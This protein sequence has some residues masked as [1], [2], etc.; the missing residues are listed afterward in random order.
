M[1]KAKEED[2][3]VVD[4]TTQT[5]RCNTCGEE[6]PIPLGVLDWVT[7]VMLAFRK[8]HRECKKGDGQRT[9]FSKPTKE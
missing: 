8:A 1:V 3:V 7:G 6:V 2:K 4:A 5:M 9:Y